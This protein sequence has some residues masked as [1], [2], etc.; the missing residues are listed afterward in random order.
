M[1]GEIAAVLLILLFI[2]HS[3]MQKETGNLYCLDI[4]YT[5]SVLIFYFKQ[6]L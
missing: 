1:S 6:Y 4:F 2:S 5:I 3:L